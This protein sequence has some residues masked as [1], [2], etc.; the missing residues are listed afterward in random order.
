MKYLSVVAV[1]K[2]E[3]PNLQEWLDFHLSVGVEHFYLYDNGSSDGSAEVLYPY[4]ES[5]KV[6]YSYNTMDM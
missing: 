5:G 2:D 4:I 6:T 1:L 3:R